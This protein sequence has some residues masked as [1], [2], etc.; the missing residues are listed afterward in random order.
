MPKV[1]NKVFPFDRGGIA[2][3]R[4][5]SRATQQPIRARQSYGDVARATANKQ[6][7]AKAA[8]KAAGS[9][10]PVATAGGGAP[11]GSPA[12][13][14]TES[15]MVEKKEDAAGVGDPSKSLGGSGVTI[16]DAITHPGALT[17]K[18]KAAGQSIAEFA[19][20]HKGDKDQTGSQARFYLNVLDKA[21]K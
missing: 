21:G 17:A 8:K 4:A 7:A 20:A 10:Q 5:E 3:A 6:I 16:Q 1:G 14:K 2:D 12:E 11:E 13:E 19:A 9:G 18:A 15:P